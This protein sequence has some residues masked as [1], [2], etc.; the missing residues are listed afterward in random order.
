M[1]PGEWFKLRDSGFESPP[2]AGIVGSSLNLRCRWVQVPSDKEC[3]FS[4]RL[5]ST[6]ERPLLD[7]HSLGRGLWWQRVTM[8][9]IIQ[10]RRCPGHQV[11]SILLPKQTP[12]PSP[13]LH[14]CS[15]AL[16]LALD[17]CHSEIMQQLSWVFSCPQFTPLLPGVNFLERTSTHVPSVRFSMTQKASRSYAQL[18]PQAFCHLLLCPSHTSHFLFSCLPVWAL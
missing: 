11:L 10:A 14:A 17:V 15:P 2:K 3:G 9:T 18:G 12:K 4:K 16:P 8:Y 1:S 13:P 7:A 5:E 6:P